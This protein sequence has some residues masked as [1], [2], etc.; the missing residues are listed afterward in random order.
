MVDIRNNSNTDRNDALCK[1][2]HW[3]RSY[4]SFL[5]EPGTL[6]TIASGLFLILAIILDP[7]GLFA[8]DEAHKAG[9]I[10]YLAAALVGSSYIWWSALNGIW[11]RD[12]T[13]DIPVSIA[14]IAAIAIGEYSAAAVVAVLLVI[15][16]ISGGVR[17]CPRSQS[18]DLWPS[19]ARLGYRSQGGRDMQLPD[20]SCRYLLLVR[21]REDCRM[22]RSSLIRSSTS[23]H[24][25]EV[26]G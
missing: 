9:S 10:L 5:L 21:S 1:T 17:G 26:R 13:A 11:E 25:G 3:L 12:F 8:H 4:R 2:R 19:S 7:G 14:T 22:E 16:R 23:G 20:E 6:F 15:G 18:L 24:N